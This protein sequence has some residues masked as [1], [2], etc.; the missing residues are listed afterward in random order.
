MKP[1]V[2][3]PLLR[4]FSSVCAAA[5]HASSVARRKTRV[6]IG[7][8]SCAAAAAVIGPRSNGGDAGGCY[9]FPLVRRLA[10]LLLAACT[11]PPQW[12]KEGARRGN[13]PADLQTGQAPGPV[14]PPPPGTAGPP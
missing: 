1:R 13:A 8:S 4:I 7:P 3:V 6:R 12:V 5:G 2:I 11:T 14:G 9:R 10:L